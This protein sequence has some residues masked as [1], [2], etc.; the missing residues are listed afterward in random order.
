VT[1]CCSS[2]PE[3]IHFS[4]CLPVKTPG[5]E[6]QLKI[7]C[8]FIC[9]PKLWVFRFQWTFSTETGWCFYKFEGDH[10]SMSVKCGMMAGD[11]WHS[12]SHRNG[13]Q[14][15]RDAAGAPVLPNQHGTLVATSRVQ[16]VI[17]HPSRLTRNYFPVCWIIWESHRLEITSIFVGRVICNQTNED[18][19]LCEHN[20]NS[21]EERLHH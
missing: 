20:Y 16:F 11:A 1:Q 4:W 10:P 21:G 18:C 15:Q 19:H 7:S 8:V 17:T 2:F 3:K 14:S 12:K 6:L 5:H 13:A 9:W